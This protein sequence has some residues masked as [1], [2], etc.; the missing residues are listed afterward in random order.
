MEI[1]DTAL[2]G[3][4]KTLPGDVAF[5]LHDT[6]GFPLDLSAD[7]YREQFVGGRSRLPSCNGATKSRRPSR[8]QIQD[9]QGA[10][11]TGDSNDFVGYDSLTQAAKS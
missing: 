5:K 4:A 9:G 1:L 10:G 8:R 3:D 11:Y 7:V 2:A 6:Y